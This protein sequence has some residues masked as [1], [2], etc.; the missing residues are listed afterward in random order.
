MSDL[1]ITDLTALAVG[2][3]ASDDLLAVVDASA[4]E[5]KKL[6]AGDLLTAGVSF[7]APGAI[8]I[9]KVDTTGIVLAADSVGSSQIITG[10]VGTDELADGSVTNVK[11]AAASL[12]A[13]KFTDQTANVVLA[14][15]IGGAAATPTFRALDAAD[16]PIATT[17]TLGGVIVP[18]PGGLVVDGAGNV[19]IGN[20]V[21]PK[22]LG[23]IDHDE[24]GLIT[25]S[26]ALLGSDIPVAGAATRGTVAVNGFGLAMSG[27][28]I[29]H[30]NNVFGA[31]LGFITYDDQGHIVAG[32]PI[33]PSDLPPA[34]ATDLGAVSIGSGLIV[35]AFGEIS[36]GL[37]DAS[38]VGGYALGP[39]FSVNAS[40]QLELFSV[41]TNILSGLIVN[42]QLDVGAVGGTNL[43]ALS[44]CKIASTLPA[45]GDYAGQLFYNT[46]NAD[47]LLWDGNT[48]RSVSTAG[49]PTLP[50]STLILAGTYDASTNRLDSV[51][52]EGSAVGYVAGAAL[53]SASPTNQACYVVVSQTGTG[54]APAPTKTLE[55]PDLLLSTGTSYQ[56]IENSQTVSGQIASNISFTPT[57]SIT[58]TNVQAALAEVDSKAGGTTLPP[59]TA[60]EEYLKWNSTLLAWQPSNTLDGGVY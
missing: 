3:V 12:T 60:A 34:N 55:P 30:T 15:P 44:T 38:T 17:T 42:R 54:V 6:A 16:L 11:L 32:R 22:S 51:T 8:P 53:P 27:D 20:T 19:T 10:A 52:A 47:L 35:N 23:W 40:N 24:N 5:T 39:E 13:D 48:Y 37:G 59:G 7:L 56:L 4:D 9:A 43:A 49:G 26:R 1:K 57:G 41:A 21:T 25:S 29:R 50:P 31:D 45:S 46:S 18:T 14:G 28:E 2:D 33:S 58:A 36:V